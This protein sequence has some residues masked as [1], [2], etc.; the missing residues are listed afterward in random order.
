MSSKQH[1]GREAVR[2]AE[3]I[4]AEARATGVMVTPTRDHI[5]VKFTTPG[6]R[7]AIVVLSCSDEPRAVHNMRSDLRRALR[8]LRG[9]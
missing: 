4:L 1:R 2:E 6:G 3:R 7:R 9:G 8:G 5:Q